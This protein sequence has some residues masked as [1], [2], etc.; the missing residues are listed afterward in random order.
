MHEKK[1]EKNQN[2]KANHEK[3]TR[4]LRKWIVIGGTFFIISRITN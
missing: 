3:K 1:T 4:K 2:N